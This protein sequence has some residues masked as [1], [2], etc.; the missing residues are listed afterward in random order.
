MLP[1]PALLHS[2]AA[3]VRGS[4][5]WGINVDWVPTGPSACGSLENFKV[6]QKDPHLKYISDR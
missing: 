3:W 2:P 5:Q 4:G 1:N 6:K